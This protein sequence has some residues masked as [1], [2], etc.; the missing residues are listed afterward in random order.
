MTSRAAMDTTRDADTSQTARRFAEIE[1]RL[2][3]LEQMLPDIARQPPL[4]GAPE[5]SEPT[6]SGRL[7]RPPASRDVPPELSPQVLAEEDP[8]T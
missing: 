3:R 8:S 7:A 5:L 1:R 4:S 6:P 2:E